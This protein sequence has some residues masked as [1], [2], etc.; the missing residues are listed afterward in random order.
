MKFDT[1]ARAVDLFTVAA[2]HTLADCKAIAAEHSAKGILGSGATA[3]RAVRAFEA[4]G[5]EALRQMLDELA[6]RVEHRGKAWRTGLA[7]VEEA[8]DG[9]MADGWNILG[10][11]IKLARADTGSAR[12]AI[13]GMLAWVKRDLHKELNA[14]RDG[15][16]APRAKAWRERH[17]ALYAVIL[18]IV[19]AILGQAVSLAGKALEPTLSIS[20]GGAPK[21]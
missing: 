18:L 2:N 8:L 16:T 11:T 14:F 15:W 10:S 21:R 12:E 1:K 9:Y 20:N 13:D 4:R 6:K 3:K 17:P 19:G 5:S 7:A